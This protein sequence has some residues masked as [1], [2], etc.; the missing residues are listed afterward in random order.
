M[1]PAPPPPHSQVG[2]TDCELQCE[3]GWVLKGE[4]IQ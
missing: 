3:L 4:K 1:N 2:K